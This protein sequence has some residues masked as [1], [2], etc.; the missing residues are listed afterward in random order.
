[1]GWLIVFLALPVEF[2]GAKFLWWTFH[3]T[4]PLLRDRFL[5]VPFHVLLYHFCFGAGFH[6]AH[7]IVKRWVLKGEYYDCLHWKTEFFLYVPL[8]S[9]LSIVLGAIFATFSYDLLF[10]VLHVFPQVSVFVFVFCMER[11]L[12]DFMTCSA[13]KTCFGLFLGASLVLIWM[14]D[15]EKSE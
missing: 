3:D 11:L 5:G 1:M 12:I 6:V 15:R 4:D 14:A 10:Q 2:L 13:W 8:V 7:Q 9:S